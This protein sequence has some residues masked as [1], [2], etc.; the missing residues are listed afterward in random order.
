MQDTFLRAWRF[1]ATWRAESSLTTWLHVICVR[2]ALEMLR[3][4][5]AGAQLVSLEAIEGLRF[6]P[7]QPSHE[8]MII[9]RLVIAHG[10]RALN[11]Q[12]RDDFT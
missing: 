3:K 4:R 11:R 9:A 12:A 2:R 10:A 1:W 6:E 7:R 8:G 5:R